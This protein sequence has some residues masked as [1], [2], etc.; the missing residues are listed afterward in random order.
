MSINNL[1]D[2]QLENF[3]ANYRR[4]KRTEGGKYTLSEILL[5]QRRRSPSPFGTR[6]VAA[7]ILELA[8]QSNDGLLTYGDLWRS[9]V[10]SH[11]GRVTVVNKSLLKASFE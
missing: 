1:T 3:A 10:R 2:K 5:E 8:R 6:E 4:S 9:S 7:K 11:L